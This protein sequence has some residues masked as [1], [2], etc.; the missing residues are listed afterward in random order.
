[1]IAR[2]SAA[3]S[4]TEHRTQYGVTLCGANSTLYKAT[5]KTEEIPIT[6]KQNGRFFIISFLPPL[7]PRVA[8]ACA[9]IHAIAVN[10]LV[11]FST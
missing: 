8:L 11:F 9:S 6:K 3:A 4:I 5:K 2:F 1:M 7:L 10:F